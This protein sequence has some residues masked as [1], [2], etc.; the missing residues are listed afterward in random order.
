M[1]S[2][3]PGQPDIAGLDKVDPNENSLRFYGIVPA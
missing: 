1:A 2:A 3:M